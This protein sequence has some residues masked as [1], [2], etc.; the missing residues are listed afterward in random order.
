MTDLKTRKLALTLA[1]NAAPYESSPSETVRAAELFLAFLI[2]PGTPAEAEP[3]TDTD[4]Y[5]D[6]EPDRYGDYPNDTYVRRFGV[7]QEFGEV[8]FGSENVWQADPDIDRERARA[9]GYTRVDH[10]RLPGWAR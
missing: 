3:I 5:V 6:E 1:V 2:G 7:G 8:M 4:Y 9:W 10:S